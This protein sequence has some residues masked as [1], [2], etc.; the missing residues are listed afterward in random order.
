[1]FEHL[2]FVNEKYVLMETAWK[3]YISYCLEADNGLNE[4]AISIFRNY[5]DSAIQFGLI[6]VLELPADK[7]TTFVASF[8]VNSDMSAFIS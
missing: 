4:M 7:L 2:A 1:M 3:D 5:N 8:N 6:K